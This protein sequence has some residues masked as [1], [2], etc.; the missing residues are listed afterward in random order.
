[1]TRKEL[2]DLA[3]K[4]G[5]KENKEKALESLRNE[6]INHFQS[7]QGRRELNNAPRVIVEGNDMYPLQNNTIETIV[8]LLLKEVEMFDFE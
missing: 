3:V 2:Y 5:I 7:E 1:M 6:L 8:D 4:H